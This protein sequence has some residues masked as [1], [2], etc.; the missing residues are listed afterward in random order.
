MREPTNIQKKI[1]NAYG[2]VG[3]KLPS[4]IF[5]L[6]HPIQYEINPIQDIY[7]RG[8]TP[9]YLEEKKSPSNPFG[10]LTEFIAYFSP[11]VELDYVCVQGDY[12]WDQV[13]DKTYTI[14]SMESYADIRV[15]ELPNR[16]AVSRT[17]YVATANGTEAQ[18]VSIVENLPCV[19]EFGSFLFGGVVP[20][21][22]PAKAGYDQVK[23]TTAIDPSLIKLGDIVTHLSVD[24]QIT[25]LVYTPQTKGAI[26][27]GQVMG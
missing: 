12:L 15:V 16:I 17:D 21:S 8:Q 22:S 27:F 18:K 3:K 26:I 19:V 9:A 7:L 6:Y 24:F 13:N 2:K 14:T 10:G 5:N 11:L 4:G 23:I 1:W 25:N 20:A